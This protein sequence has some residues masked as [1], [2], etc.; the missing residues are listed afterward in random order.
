M[1]WSFLP[2]FLTSW[3][4]L[5]MIL[6]KREA[7]KFWLEYWCCKRNFLSVKISNHGIQK[8]DVEKDQKNK[9]LFAAA[10]LLIG[11]EEGGLIPHMGTLPPSLCVEKPV[12]SNLP[13]D[14][15]I[16]ELTAE[17]ITPGQEQ[18]KDTFLSILV[19]VS[20]K[21]WKIKDIQ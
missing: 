6:E 16:W 19:Y 18:V 4:N 5:V 8:S 1:N 13:W 11:L 21:F 10:A 9:R 7:K 17:S 20:S 15:T 3:K 14:S 2:P 12:E